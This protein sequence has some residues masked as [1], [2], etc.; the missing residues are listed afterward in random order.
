MLYVVAI[1]KKRSHD[2]HGERWR[3]SYG[4]FKKIRCSCRSVISKGSVDWFK[5]PNNNYQDVCVK[6]TFSEWMSLIFGIQCHIEQL[7]VWWRGSVIS[8]C[9]WYR[10][11]N[12]YCKRLLVFSIQITLWGECFI[13]R[14]PLVVLSKR[15][16]IQVT[17]HV[18][19][20]CGGA[21]D[22]QGISIVRKTSSSGSVYF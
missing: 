20:C 13:S 21:F 4:R 5:S 16:K 14:W 1:W 12:T 2:M 18:V 6:I 15:S 8:F 3:T 10:C 22:F 9:V 11:W 17:S 7:M 19:L